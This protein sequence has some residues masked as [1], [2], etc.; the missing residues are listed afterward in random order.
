MK[1]II[2]KKYG[3]AT[4]SS[5]EKIKSIAMQLSDLHNQGKSLVVVVSAMGKTTNDLINLAQQVSQ[6]P[7]R[8]EMDMLLSTGE[9]ISMSLLSM[10]LNDLKCPAISFTGSQAGIL[11]DESHSNAIIKDVKPLRI[12]EALDKN[13][14]VIL[15]GFQGVSPITKEVTTLG[16]GG[17]DTTAVAIAAA[18]NAHH[19]EILKDV[20]SIFSADPNIIPTAQKISKLTYQQLLEMTFWGA[21][22]LHYRS[23]ELSYLRQVPLYI[24]PA[25]SVSEGTWIEGSIEGDKEMQQL[26]NSNPKTAHL[27]F[28]Q[29]RIISINSH[30]NVLCIRIQSQES[31][32]ALLKL[33]NFLN[34]KEI[35]SPQILYIQNP[36]N[37]SKIN[38][39]NES[40]QFFDIFL[41][42][43]TENI[44]AIQKS[45]RENKEFSF[46]QAPS[47][48]SS[49]TNSE[50][51]TV[52]ATCSSVN[53]STLLTQMTEKLNAKNISFSHLFISGMTITFFLA[54]TQRV[55]AIE[56][57]HEIISPLNS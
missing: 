55:L 24:G 32:S 21:K 12:I 47:P 9:R 27:Q 42:A 14:V 46:I 23:A 31:A 11:T 7:L 29:S 50:W 48:I 51:S 36:T 18:L 5:P 54:K 43:P 26:K 3:G 22:V 1:K 28:E 2:V 49:I 53:N 17:S 13:Q 10:A 8:R 45:L 33:E 56:T 39:L 41:T 4:L 44:I 35:Y 38:K 34:Q 19:C 52:S 6:T 30:E 16:R 25:H 57:L 37:D 15:A 20:P 40:K